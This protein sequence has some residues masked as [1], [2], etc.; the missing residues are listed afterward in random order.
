MFFTEN[1][2]YSSVNYPG[3]L[4]KALAYVQVDLC[5][6]SFIFYDSLATSWTSLQ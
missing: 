2:F 3:H 6:S 5:R 4:Y 1:S